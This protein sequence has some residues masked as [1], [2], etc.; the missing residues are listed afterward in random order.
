MRCLS[1]VVLALLCAAS[2]TLPA[3]RAAYA[4]GIEYPDNGTIAIGRGGADA[5]NPDDGLAFQYNPAGLAQQR[6]LRLTMDARLSHQGLTFASS[7][8]HAAIVSNTAAPFLGPSGALSYGLGEVGPLSELTFAIGATGPSSIGKTQF[9]ENGAQRYAITSTDYFI[10]YYSAAVAAG[11]SD[12]LRV[13]ITGQLVKGNA[14][15]A[16]AV[17][18][19]PGK[20]TNINNTT[21]DT[22]AV[23]EGTS[24]FTPAMVVGLTVLPHKD[25]AIGLSYRPK[26]SFNA[27]GTMTMNAPQTAKDA[28]IS[29]NGNKADLL[30]SLASTV[31]LG[32]QYNPSPRLKME[33]DAVYER[34]SELQTIEIHTHGIT[35]QA[36]DDKGNITE[37]ASVPNIIFQHHFQDTISGRVGA[38]YALLPERLTVRGG[39]LHETTAVP[40]AYQSVDFGNWAR[41]AVS[42]GASVQIF[43]A[44]LDL[45]YAHHF[46]QTTTVTN[47]QVVQ[48]VSPPMPSGFPPASVASVVGNGTYSASMDIFSLSLRVPFGDLKQSF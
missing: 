27:P 45:A 48:Q 41:D 7:Q 17:W 37:Q 42:L 47:S 5:A 13:G 14:K 20:S 18:S 35:V 10:G 1:R 31:R 33:V 24:D 28:L 23:F 6:G 4:A 15:F 11:Y 3:S 19:G 39:Y 43:G 40:Q 30:L 44:W 32:I 25:W 9:P 22:T 26:I 21:F 2:A 12:W 46:V 34:W 29:T 16:Q 38:D 36:H 8:P